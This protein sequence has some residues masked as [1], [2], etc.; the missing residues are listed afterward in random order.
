MELALFAVVGVSVI[1]TVAAFSKRLGIAAPIILV[2]V[3]FA[4]SYTPGVP[5]FSVPHEWILMGV[6]PPLLYA[7]AVNVPVVDFRR[8]IGA[9]SSLS[10]FL[11][12]VSAFATG[13]VLYV[14]LPDLNFAAAVALGAVVS[15]PDAVAATAIGKRLGLPPRLVTVL[16][17]EGLVN[18]ATALVLLRSAVAASA[19]GLSSIWAGIGDFGFAVITAIAVGLL[20]GA[21]T[22]FLRS[23]LHDPVLD[24]AISFVV[25][26]VAFI[27][28]EEVGASGVLAV[29]VAGLYTGHRSASAFTAQVRINDSINW[30]TISFLL[31]NGVFLLMGLELR[32]LVE[33]V[34]TALLSVWDA[35]LIGLITTGL[36]VLVRFAWVTPLIYV[37][38]AKVRYQD[39]R[40]Q[41]F[42]LGLDR[43]KAG[44]FT[45]ERK[46]R[47]HRR[48]ELLYRRRRAD[49]EQLRREGLGWRGGV[50][51]SWSGMRGVVTLAAA[52]SLPEQTPYREQLVLIAFTVA[53]ATLLLQGGTLPWVIR[54]LGV[55]GRDVAADQREL[56]KLLDELSG[57]GLTI[58]EEPAE[59]LGAREEVDPDVVERVRQSTFLRS[60]LA[61]E[62]VRALGMSEEATP[63]LQ[64]R[65]LRRAVVEAERDQLLVARREGRY[66]SRTLAEAQRLLDLEESRLRPRLG[67]R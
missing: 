39:L 29:V 62:R 63:Q 61:W 2:V 25:P 33:N 44:G 14:L 58:L 18:D 42:R 12:L 11:V 54:V 4:L 40:T 36:L 41:R 60:E 38:R 13:T 30:R 1:V 23:K 67:E 52:Q 59:C 35:V 28:A 20:V 50:V 46:R 66:A 9:I 55:Q 15:P 65:R 49:V 31:E 6:L 32:H 56:A 21:A 22:V 45:N 16:E 57:A 26:F 48:A 34:D 24:T 53:V 3:G 7:A 47:R 51:I 19:G 43:I 27:P 8:N 64:Y 17:G 10:V 37:L 5:A